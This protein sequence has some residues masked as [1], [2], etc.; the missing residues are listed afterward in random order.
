M[1]R[2]SKMTDYGSVLL[3]FMA[4]HPNQIFS[5]AS[6]A[7]AIYLPPTTVSKLLKILHSSGLVH[8]TR[9]KKGGYRLAYPA[10]QITLAQIVDALEGSIAVT[11]CSIKKDLCQIE[12]HCE[13]RGHWLGINRV[14]YNSLAQVTL[15]DMISHEI[16]PEPL[17]LTR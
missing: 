16:K 17:T 10:Q 7:R 12:K 3:T 6:L 11:E 2:V 9:G 5:T 13:I 8:S 1:L 4:R 15:Q 14:I